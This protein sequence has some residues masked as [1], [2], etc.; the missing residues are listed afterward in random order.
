MDTS[1]YF[2]SQA[3]HLFLHLLLKASYKDRDIIFNNKIVKLKAG[4]FITGRKKLAEETSISESKIYRLLDIFE[5]ENL[6]EQQPN[7]RY[8]IISIKNW[9]EYQEV[10]QQVNSN[11]TA[12]EQQMNTNNKDKK[13]KKDKKFIKP[14]I[15]QLQD[16]CIEKNNNIDVEYFYNH[17]ESNGWKVGSNKMKDWK[18]TINQWVSREKKKKEQETKKTIGYGGLF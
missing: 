7:S 6:I 17:Y 2:N 9:S 11:R 10:E 18:A 15:E 14:T 8:S 12:S 13:D 5:N 16:Y 1:I 3:V 4:Q